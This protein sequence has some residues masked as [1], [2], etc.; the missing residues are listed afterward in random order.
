MSVYLR[1]L[2][3][4]WRRCLL[5]SDFSIFIGNYDKTPLGIHQDSR[6]QN[7]MHFHLGPHAKTICVWRRDEF[8]D[9]LLSKGLTKDDQNSLVP[10]SQKYTFNTGDIFFM[11]EGEWHI[12]QQSGLSVAVTVWQY[13]HTNERLAASLSTR[14]LRSFDIQD[15]VRI[16]ADPN[17]LDD[18][19]AVS[20]LLNSMSIS[21]RLANLGFKDLMREAY[22]DMKYSIHSNGGYRGKPFEKPVPEIWR[23]EELVTG[24]L[25]YVIQIRAIGA[26]KIIIYVRGTAVEILDHPGIKDVVRVLNTG[27]QTSVIELLS[28]LPTD[29]PTEIGKFFLGQ[30][31]RFGGV[32]RHLSH[33]LQH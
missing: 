28:L 16:E 11:P 31:F 26:E 2:P 19:S 9:L 13:N 4:R 6:G 5:R 17:L 32:V 8:A 30:L 7:V 23:D 15:K 20:G 1:G 12:S 24:N 10:Y 22:A 21:A 25:P 14:L 29:W 27:K 18:T 3:H 33:S